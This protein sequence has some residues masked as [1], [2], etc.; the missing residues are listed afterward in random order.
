ML[1]TS[2]HPPPAKP[3]LWLAASLADGVVAL[4]DPRRVGFAVAGADVRRQPNTPLRPRT[5]MELSRVCMT[6]A[7]IVCSDQCR[8]DVL[9]SMATG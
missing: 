2:F 4:R 3:P 9:R 7:M 1:N 6:N 8:I 5:V